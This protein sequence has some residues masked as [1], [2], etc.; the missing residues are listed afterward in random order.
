M[1]SYPQRTEPWQFPGRWEVRPYQRET[2][3]QDR[4]KHPNKKK[5]KRKFPQWAQ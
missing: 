4:R 3:P 5:K 1:P 2:I